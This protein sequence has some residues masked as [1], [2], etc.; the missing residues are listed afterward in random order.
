MITN[1]DDNIARLRQS[2]K[3]QGL[4]KNTV[5]I[6]FGD[7]GPNNVK[8]DKKGFTTEKS[9]YN[10]GFRGKK[11]MAWEGGHRQAMLMHI[12]DQTNGTTDTELAM[13]YDIMPT[14]INLCDLKPKQKLRLDGVD[15]L[16]DESRAGRI[17]VVDTQRQEFLR[18][19]ATSAVMMDEWRLIDRK[20]LYNLASDREQRVDV[21]KSHPEIVKKLRA[22][23]DE[24]WRYVA[25]DEDVRHPIYLSTDVK[26][27]SVVFNSHDLHTLNKKMPVWNQLAS[28][29]SVNPEG[30]WAVYAPQSGRYDFELYRWNPVTGLNLDEAAPA[31]RQVPDGG[32]DPKGLAITDMKSAA[33]YVDGKLVGSCSK[34]KTNR[35]SI[36]IPSVKIKEG[37]HELRAEITNAE[38]ESYPAWFV[39]STKR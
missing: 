26:G 1:I 16:S 27:E 12:P 33:I 15:I 32:R 6:L 21:A 37:Y 10:G 34:F 35:P 20:A 8:L 25:E 22:A 19:N 39:R 13:C 7:N 38:G 24:W 29:R 23:H 17:A 3:E 5:I 4:D 18:S 30:F 36:S 2:L 11:S 14:L 31:G 28:R 9:A